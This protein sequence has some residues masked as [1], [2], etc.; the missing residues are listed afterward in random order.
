MNRPFS[1]GPFE[2]RMD[3]LRGRMDGEGPNEALLH[4][5]HCLRVAVRHSGDMVVV[6]HGFVMPG[7]DKS[8]KQ[9]EITTKAENGEYDSFDAV[10]LTHKQ[11]DALAAWWNEQRSNGK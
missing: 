11:M 8:K 6:S 7:G 4:D 5:G 10:H 3:R 9:Q 2:Y 1:T